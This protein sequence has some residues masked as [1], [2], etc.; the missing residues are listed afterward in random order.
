MRVGLNLLYLIPG[1]VGGTETYAVSLIK[2]LAAVDST[3]EYYIF[4]NQEA[5]QSS[6]VDSPN[7]QQVVCPFQA[8]C[9]PQRYAWEQ[10]VLPWQ[11]RY[12]QVDLVHSLGYVGPL[13]VP[14]PG[15]V[16]IYDLNYIALRTEMPSARA[17]ILSYFVEQS[18]RRSMHII[19]VSQFSKL[20]LMKYVKVDPG[21]ITVVHGAP[22]IAAPATLSVHWNAVAARYQIQPP[23]VLAF[24]GLSAHKNTLR[25]VRAFA[26]VSSEFSHSLVLVG[27]LAPRTNLVTEISTSGLSHRVVIT[28]YVPDEHIL[29]LLGHADLFVLPSWHEGFG[30]P[31]LEAQQ[32][33]V[34]VACSTAGSLPEVAGEGALFFDPY[35]V[36]DM[37]RAIRRCLDSADLRWTLIQK[38]L[39]NLA[40]FSW[41]KSARETL[42]VY[43][44]ILTRRQQ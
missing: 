27:H 39:D 17:R 8:T 16:T 3:N 30:L 33:G 4:L 11:L 21:K 42:E 32:A 43:Q 5:A 34:P 31:V 25:L 28:G 36:E 1:V 26:E 10:A 19:T 6:L 29:P 18:A 14:H 22:R 23:Y 44:Q 20:Q 2:A 37:A 7:F 38:G 13:F 24:T 40:R 41:E 15:V 12:Y 9:R 35:S